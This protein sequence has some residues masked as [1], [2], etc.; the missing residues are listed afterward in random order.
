[1]K[2]K[3]SSKTEHNGSHSKDMISKL[4]QPILHHILSFLSKKCAT[5]TSVLSKPWRQIWSSRPKI[6]LCERD[7]PWGRFFSAL[8]NIF[9]RYHDQNLSVQELYLEIDFDYVSVF[10]VLNKWMPI[11]KVFNLNLSLKYCGVI[12]FPILVARSLKNLY[13]ESCTLSHQNP[14]SVG[15]F[16]YL[17]TLHLF[18]V[19]VRDD[20]DAIGKMVSSCPRLK[21]LT[22]REIN[23]SNDSLNFFSFNH[24]PS[25][26]YLDLHSCY[27]FTEFHL[28]SHSIKHLI[29]YNY[30]NDSFEKVTIHAPSI[31]YFKYSSSYILSSISFT[32]TNDHEWKSEINLSFEK[33][34]SS[35]F[36]KLNK[37]LSA[38]SRSEMSLTLCSCLMK[39]IEDSVDDDTCLY[40]RPVMVENLNLY[41]RPAVLFRGFIHNILF[42]VCHPR[43]IANKCVHNMEPEHKEVNEVLYEILIMEIEATGHYL[44]RQDLENVRVE[45][46]DES[47]KVGQWRRLVQRTSLAD[48][49]NLCF[50]L[51]WS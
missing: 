39:E 17:Q 50:R 38:L 42:S 3:Q 36:V 32:T 4:P 41:L 48:H 47:R 31:L 24:L 43:N 29:I 44:W 25:L 13:M 35:W 19:F 21:S 34:D 6:E 1:M 37:L 16:K 46:F 27:G 7:F 23:F 20:A 10:S 9:Q 40:R 11:V 30:L 14:S 18:S 45:A 8:D 33:A 2:K 15:K 49:N 12:A 28:L 22:L 51:K 26:E 5:Q